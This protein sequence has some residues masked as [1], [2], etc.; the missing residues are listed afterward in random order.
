MALGRKT[1]RTVVV[2]FMDGEPLSYRKTRMASHAI[3]KKSRLVFVVV[4][5]FSPLKDIKTWSSRRWQENVVSVASAAELA[6]PET[7]T[8]L[9]ANICPKE[10]PKLKTKRSTR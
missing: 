4:N 6:L 3:R 7:G 8:H 5:K 10:F 1:A 9:I 2:V